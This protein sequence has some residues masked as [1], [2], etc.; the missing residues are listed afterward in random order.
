MKPVIIGFPESTSLSQSLKRELQAQTGEL[1][2]RHFPDGESYLRLVS[3]VA[4]AP[5]IIVGSLDRP[6]AK[7]LPL[8]FA[9]QTA[10]IMNARSVGL[11]APYLPYLRQ[12]KSFHKGEAV[13]SISFAGLI[14]EHFDWLVSVSPHLH[15]YHALSD[16]YSIPTTSVQATSLISEWISQRVTNPLIIGPDQESE[17]WVSAISQSSGAP[18]L[19]LEKHRIGDEEV[20]IR[21][22]DV[23]KWKHHTPVL[24]D[25]IVSTAR[26]MIETIERMVEAGLK[27]PICIGIHAVFAGTA[28]EDLLNAGAASVITSDTIAHESNEIDICG[29]LVPAIERALSE[30]TT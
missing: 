26:T 4:D 3:D 1:E 21:V 30:Q 25:D 7:I 28:Y 14:S 6:D 15:R 5:V 20:N 22:P 2:F 11:V 16:V 9:A 17:Q 29:I 10:K 27:K 19:V 24:V 13:T 8:I 18:Y 23:E 12:D